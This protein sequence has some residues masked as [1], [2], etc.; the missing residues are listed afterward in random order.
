MSEVFKI[1]MLH[2]LQ[3]IVGSFLLQTDDKQTRFR[4]AKQQFY[5]LQIRLSKN[6]KIGIKLNAFKR[7]CKI[8]LFVY[9]FFVILNWNWA[10]ADKA[11]LS[12]CW[13]NTWFLRPCIA[14]HNVLNNLK[15]IS[16]VD[17]CY[18]DL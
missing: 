13:F 15:R 18:L 4:K 8:L 16:L 1:A 10:R 7:V 17:D 12:Y 9:C 11:S 5:W 6:Y 3:N 14:L 2:R